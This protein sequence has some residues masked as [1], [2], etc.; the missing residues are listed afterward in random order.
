MASHTGQKVFV[1]PFLVSVMKGLL[2]RK[3]R[4]A[5]SGLAVMLGVMAVAGALILT[6]H[7]SYS[8]TSMFRTVSSDI[9]VQVTSKPAVDESDDPGPPAP[10]QIQASTISTIESVDGVQS[11]DGRVYVEG[12]KVIGKDGKMAVLNAPRFGEAWR[13]ETDVVQLRSGRGPRAPNEVAINATLAK[14]A[15]FSVGD[16]VGIL[17]LEP[18]RE[19]TVVGVFGYTGDR[20]TF[21]GESRVAFE[22]TT[23]A[24]LLLGAVDVYSSIDVTAKSGISVAQLRDE[25]RKTLGDDYEVKT[26][27]QVADEQAAT[28]QEIVSRLRSVLLGFAAVAL[29]VG[30]F[31]IV[32][33][34]S[35]LIAQRTKELA[36]LR[37]LGASAKQMV[38]SVLVEATAIGLLASAVG[39]FAGLGVANLL[40][41]LMEANSGIQLPAIGF[42]LPASVI[43]T[44][45]VVGVVVTVAA[46]VVPALRASRVPPIAAM[47][48][49]ATKDKPLTV[50]TLG[51]LLA[52]IVGSAAIALALTVDL[53]NELWVLLAG[54]VVAFIGVTMLTPA[55]SGPAVSVLGRAMSWSLPGALGRRNAARNPRRTAITAAALMVGITLVTGISVVAS[56][57]KSSISEVLRS[58]VHAE[59]VIA[60]EQS[61][62]TPPS[63]DAKIMPKVREIDGVRSAVAL[64]TDQVQ[65]SGKRVTATATDIAGLKPIVDLRVKDGLLRALR[66]GEVL[67]DDEFAD[68]RRVSVGE[69]IP[70]AARRGAERHLTVVGVFERSQVLGSAMLLSEADAAGHFRTP[71]ASR[72]YITVPD[73]SRVDNVRKQINAL[74]HDNPEVSAM[75]LSG[76][77][78]QQN[79][80]V[81]MIVTMLFV[82][83]ALALLI[84]VLGIVNTLTLSIVERTRELGLVRAI[85]MARKQVVAMV[86]TESV[87]VAVFGALLGMVVGT[88][89][90]AG[91]V[92]AL[93]DSGI[94]TLTIPWFWLATFAGGAVLVG[95]LAGF[96]PALKASR[97]NILR[98]IAYE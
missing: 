47:R 53:G 57:F 31:L 65:A 24:T 50:M 76:F 69:A 21:F 79:G 8:F 34:F 10:T 55:L 46:A 35:I 29:F 42:S 94:T 40:M 22:P 30:I 14:D 59:L 19:F 26:G 95:L 90:G 48:E 88:A 41:M 20:G 74:V 73:E 78:A 63:F 81:D 68:D 36:L 92:A 4:L 3:L 15:G 28:S 5:L 49:L 89:L 97:V 86:T 23:A 43:I 27:A 39:L 77:V 33:T 80:Q 1:E 66:P 71:Q 2:S 44:A 52:S 83:V 51:G 17:T 11:A 61:G 60:G 87:V 91:A 85:G 25:L 45:F 18:K 37:S 16:T 93:R 54:I 6:D 56:S 96:G 70:V 58:D 98:A 62:P 38:G 72:A 13:G 64:Y 12:A 32:N 67:I 7:L 82:L 75:D 84:A 9:D